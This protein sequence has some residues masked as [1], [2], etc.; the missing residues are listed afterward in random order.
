VFPSRPTEA[1]L[2]LQIKDKD[3]DSLVTAH[4][5][6][7]G[8]EMLLTNRWRRGYQALHA[9]RTFLT[10]QFPGKKLNSMV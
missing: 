4:G 6:L 3:K 5:G 1:F 9:D 10:E 7:W 2:A 8:Y